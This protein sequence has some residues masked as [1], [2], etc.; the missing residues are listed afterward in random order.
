MIE[1]EVTERYWVPEPAIELP[2]EDGEPLESPWHRAQINLLIE[3]VHAHLRDRD[4]YFVGGNMFLYYSA[5]QARRRDYKGPDFFSC[6]PPKVRGRDRPGSSGKR[7]ASI[8]I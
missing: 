3:C 5:Q 2:T 7:T 8:P 6:P 4:D 1:I